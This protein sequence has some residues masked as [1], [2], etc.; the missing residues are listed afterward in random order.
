MPERVLRTRRGVT[1]WCEEAT[2]A[3]EL[4]EG[5]AARVRPVLDHDAGAWLL[6]DPAT[7]LFTDGLVEGF[8][9]ATCTP[10][11]HHELSVPNVA[12]FAE[13]ARQRAGVAVL[14]QATGGDVTTSPRWR[15]VLEP[16]GFGRE[17]RVVFREGRSTW[18]VAAVHRE[19]NRADFTVADARL[20]ADLSGVVARGLR[21]LAVAEQLDARIPGGPGL[22]LVGPDHVVRPGTP[23][24]AEWLELLGVPQG[25]ARHAWLLTLGELATG[26]G[27]SRR[28]VRVRARDGRWVTLHGE[29]MTD[30]H[31]TFAVIVEPSRP[32]DVAGI[33]ALAY[34][35]SQREQD[36]V[37]ALARGEGTEA[38]AEALCISTHT[39][40]DHL[41]S[42]FDKTGV[43]SR[44]ELLARLFHD[45]YAEPFFERVAA[46]H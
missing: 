3:G 18:G 25:S 15:E 44:N 11:F 17:L 45:H 35:L 13:L 42:I 12:T 14:S 23:A 24:G 21:R 7:V 27:T 6:T 38:M 29:P 22:L 9:E 30:G 4:L 16:A 40:R 1:R 32:A 26:A 28:R 39:V 43:S 34:G 5:V 46:A 41:K 20:L 31:A 2:S 19:T 37:L 8:S 10:W 33:A 36:L